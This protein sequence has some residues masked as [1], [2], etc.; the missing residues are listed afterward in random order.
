M[1]RCPGQDMRYWTPED[2]FDVNC[3]YCDYS[4]EFWRDEPVRVCR[5][6]HKEVRNPRIDLGC[7]KWCKFGDQCLGRSVSEQFGAE[8]VVEKLK[9]LVQPLAEKDP[10]RYEVLQETVRIAN[11]L[12]TAEG[13]DPCRVKAG[14]M[15]VPAVQ[16]AADPVAAARKVLEATILDDEEVDAICSLIGQVLSG[17]DSASVDA[18]VVRDALILADSSRQSD[19]DL[20]RL[21]TEGAQMIFNLRRKKMKSSNE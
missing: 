3:P 8:P 14:A 6:C 15:L 2:I 9:A 11:L 20:E 13:G 4:I 19:A 5:A 12:L 7:A 17:D 1:P 16:D 18:S 21:S 10:E